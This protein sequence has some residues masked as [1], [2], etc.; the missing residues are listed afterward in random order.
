MVYRATPTT[1]TGMSPCKLLIDTSP[2]EHFETRRP[3][4]NSIE[5][6]DKRAK[7][8]CAKFYNR[9]HGA[10][11]LQPLQEGEEVLLKLDGEKGWKN[12]AIVGSRQGPRSHL[13]HTAG[14]GQYRR[15]RKRLQLIPPDSRPHEMPNA[16]VDVDTESENQA[17]T[18]TL[19]RPSQS[20]AAKSPVADRPDVIR[21]R[22][23]RAV[24][25]PL[26]FRSTVKR[27]FVQTLCFMNVWCKDYPKE[28]YRT[29]AW[30]LQLIDHLCVIQSNCA[31]NFWCYNDNKTYSKPN[32]V[33]RPV[34]HRV[35]WSI[36]SMVPLNSRYRARGFLC[37]DFDK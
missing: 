11:P 1:C 32:W 24:I 15:N 22:S 19:Q 18:P 8:A 2:G 5:E 12:P 29:K 20:P 14:G 17:I 9:R 4:R 25:K 10:R 3:K 34:Y 26:H 23:G 33:F 28:H 16:A 35:C 27:T 21:T 7:A 36:V 37:L 6:A 31:A 30:T 13:V